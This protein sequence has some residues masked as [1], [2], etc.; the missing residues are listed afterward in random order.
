M[1]IWNIALKEIKQNIRDRRTFLFM[2][3]FPIVLMLILGTSLS[4]AFN[5]KISVDNIRVL[6]KSTADPSV[7]ASFEAFAN[8]AA[9]SGIHFKRTTNHMDGKKEVKENNYTAYVEISDKGIQ[10]YSSDQNNI[11]ESIVQGMLKAYADKFNVA[12]AIASIA[13][14]KVNIIMKDEQKNNF[15][16][17]RSLKEAKQQS[18]MDYYAVAMTTMIALYG[19]IYASSLIRSERVRN[20][21]LRLVAA[22]IGKGEIFLGKILGYLFVNALCLL[23]V[24]IFSHFVF[25]ANWGDHLVIVFVLLLSEVF[26]ALS[27]GLGISYMAK[28]P[29]ASRMIIMVFLQLSSFFGG[30]Y[31]KIENEAGILGFITNLSPLTWANQAITKIIYMNDFGSVLPAISLNLGISVLFL[32]IAIV[33]FQRREGL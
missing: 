11:E 8:E 30:A 33:L 31:F 12:A 29:D 5:Q 27:L 24:I 10:L 3:A 22:P 7:T 17:V 15:I 9:K 13:P 4:N 32:G 6:Y 21:A 20:T 19:A 1:N 28:T 16:Q 23:G 26:L 14:D 18:S 2:L 25:K